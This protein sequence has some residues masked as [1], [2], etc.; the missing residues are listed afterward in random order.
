MLRVYHMATE[1]S[2]PSRRR[3]AQGHWIWRTS[4][5]QLPVVEKGS[6]ELR[7]VLTM[8]DIFRA[9]A[10]AAQESTGAESRRE[11]GEDP[12]ESAAG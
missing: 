4:P 7:G 2:G 9:Q 5:G 8:S 12:P 10:E 3:Q 11:A 6:R 1:L